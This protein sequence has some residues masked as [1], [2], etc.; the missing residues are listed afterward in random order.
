MARTGYG[1]DP[2]GKYERYSIFGSVACPRPDPNYKWPA[3]AKTG[4]VAP[5]PVLLSS[6][7]G[8]EW[9]DGTPPTT[10]ATPS[11]QAAAASAWSTILD[12]KLGY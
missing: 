2:F 8:F 4:S 11:R 5:S 3:A 1:I 12:P 6:K 7:G 9:N 10:A